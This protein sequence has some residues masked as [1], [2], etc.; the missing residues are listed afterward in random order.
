MYK[1]QTQPK[2]QA[3]NYFTI[4]P[5]PWIE[6][7]RLTD[8]DT[9]VKINIKKATRDESLLI[10]NQQDYNMDGDILSF[11]SYG[12]YKGNFFSNYYL[13]EQFYNVSI[14]LTQSQMDARAEKYMIMKNSP[15]MD[16]DDGII[17]GFILG[18]IE[19]EEF[20]FYIFVMPML[21]T[22]SNG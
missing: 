1:I 7:V 16:F 9:D 22:R 2:P 11:F 3:N 14:Q 13:D 4:E 8:D 10:G 19:D 21:P 18:K 20:V 15:E 5:Q 17:N 12:Y 6:E